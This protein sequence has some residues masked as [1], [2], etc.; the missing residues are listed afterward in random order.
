MGLVV[1]MFY[2]MKQQRLK[3]KVRKKDIL[4]LEC[5]YISKSGFSNPALLHEA[6]RENSH[7]PLQQKWEEQL[8]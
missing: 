5:I 8:G 6:E 4:Y 3:I 1:I 2:G 7:L